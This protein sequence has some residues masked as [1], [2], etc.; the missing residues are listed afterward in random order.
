MKCVRGGG[1]DGGGVVLHTPHTAQGGG[2]GVGG[3]IY[4]TQRAANEMEAERVLEF[5]P[6]FSKRC[7]FAS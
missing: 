1:G 6:N 3:G 2:G 5:E 7:V 4:S